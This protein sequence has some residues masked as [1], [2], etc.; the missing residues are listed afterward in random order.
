MLNDLNGKSVL[1]TG[2]TK[3]IGLAIGLAFGRQGAV[4]TLTHKW[5]SAD[6]DEIRK[7]FSAIGAPEPFIVEADA[8]EDEDTTALLQGMRD[9]SDRIEVF[10]P[11][12]AFAQV[13]DSLEDYSK[14]SL[15]QSVE[16]TSWPVV[17]YVNKIKDVFGYYPRYVV[18]LSSGGP[19]EFHASYDIVAACKSMLETFCRYLAY[20]LRDDDVRVNVVRARF[21]R[22]E[23]LEATLG[24]EFEP[25]IDRYDPDFFISVED[26]ANTILALCSGLMDGVSGQVLNVDRGTKF[27]DNLMGMYDQRD[28]RSILPKEKT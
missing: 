5:G 12:A 1:I 4:C 13:V 7:Q 19:D 23:S 15:L 21:V 10:V 27:A 6:E 28:Q 20:R 25:F 26:V 14:R 8:R 3:G 22:T 16:Y 17:A 18:G 2:G 11:G 24:A 9:R